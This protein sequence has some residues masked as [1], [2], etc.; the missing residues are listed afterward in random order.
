M[1]IGLMSDSHNNHP[2]V[3]Y[4]LDIFRELGINTILHAGDLISGELLKEFKGLSLYLAFGNGD[5][6]LMISVKAAGISSQ[7]VCEE[8]LALCLDG[9]KI[10][11]IHGDQRTEL[12]NQIASGEHDYVIHG[13][14]HQFRN[15][16]VDN[17]RVI[18]PGALGGRFV[19]ERSFATLDLSK[20]E[21]QR[22]FVP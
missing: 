9:R 5:D 20:N 15:E 16:M 19:G 13:H 4:A 6:P 10:F 12:E 18:N 22:Y 14:T 1:L 7:F 11:M 2:N 17:T 3:R 8:A 21:L